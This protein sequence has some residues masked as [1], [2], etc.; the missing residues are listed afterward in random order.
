[1]LEYYKT[2]RTIPMSSTSDPKLPQSSHFP[3]L[4]STEWYVDADGAIQK[5][6]R[7]GTCPVVADHV[8]HNEFATE[9]GGVFIKSCDHERINVGFNKAKYVCKKCDIVLEE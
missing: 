1:M 4:Q 9:Y 8:E 2:T 6:P 5:G 3:T 7:P